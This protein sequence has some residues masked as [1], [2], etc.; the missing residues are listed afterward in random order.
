MTD[1]PE[2][3][4]EEYHKEYLTLRSD[5][6]HSLDM[7]FDAAGAAAERCIRKNMEIDAKGKPK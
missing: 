5:F 6:I 2:L 7:S 4:P 1:P 3:W